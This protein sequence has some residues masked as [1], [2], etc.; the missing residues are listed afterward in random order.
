MSKCLVG[1]CVLFYNFHN[2]LI[3]THT[4]THTHTHLRIQIPM[5]IAH[6]AD[7]SARDFVAYNLIP[8]TIGNW[9]VSGTFYN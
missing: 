3:T 7:I 8:A 2:K 1:M 9:I 5:A 4:H 6:G